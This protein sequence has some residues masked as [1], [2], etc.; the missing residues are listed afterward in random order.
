MKL[1]LKIGET[2]LC[3]AGQSVLRVDIKYDIKKELLI[4]RVLFKI[5]VKDLIMK[6]KAIDWEKYLQTTYQEKDSNL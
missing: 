1:I 6:M 4:S 5:F 3:Q 2:F